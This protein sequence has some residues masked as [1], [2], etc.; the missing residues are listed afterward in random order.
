MDV[1]GTDVVCLGEAE[2]GEDVERA[3]GICEG[4]M[5]V[6]QGVVRPG[7]VVWL[8]EVFGEAE[9]V[10]QVGERAAG[11]TGGLVDPPEPEQRLELAVAAARIPG[12]A[13]GLLE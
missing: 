13:E 9:R 4:P 7:L 10:L 8:A 11:I 6:R 12:E 5:Y 2:V 3:F 1:V